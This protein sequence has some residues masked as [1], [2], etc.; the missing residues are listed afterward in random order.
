MLRAGAVVRTFFLRLRRAEFK[1]LGCGLGV[2]GVG[3]GWGFLGL[4]FRGLGNAAR[5]HETGHSSQV[6]LHLS[7]SAPK[8]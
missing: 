2:R 5:T 1:C 4:G 3:F 7:S 8:P 6:F